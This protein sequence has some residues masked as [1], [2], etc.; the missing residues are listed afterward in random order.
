MGYLLA[1]FSS[2]L[3]SNAIIIIC[4]SLQGTLIPL[5]GGLEN[6]AESLL[7]IIGGAYYA[8]FIFGSIHCAKVVKRAGHIRAF[9]VFASLAS[10]NPL[11]HGMFPNE[12]LWI[13]LRSLSG[14]CYAGL[15]LVIESWL[16]EQVDRDNRGRLFAVYLIVNLLSLT[17]AQLTINLAS[18]T[19]IT[20]FVLTSILASLALLPV[21]LTKTIQPAPVERTKLDLKALWNMSP[22]G[23]MGCFIVGIS[24]GPLWTLGPV[25]AQDAGLG[26]RE[27]SF[28][29]TA[30][31]LGGAALQWPIGRLS[32]LTDRRWIVIVLNLGSSLSGYLLIQ[33]AGMNFFLG[34][35][36]SAVVLGAFSLNLYGVCVALTN[37]NAPKGD[38]VVVSGGLLLV[39]SIGAF[40]GPL[41]VS[42]VMIYLGTDAIFFFTATIHSCFIIF[43]LMRIWIEPAM[44]VSE[45][46]NFAPMSVSQTAPKP[47]EFDPRANIEKEG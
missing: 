23:L 37:D 21:S 47:L 5:R 7:G 15:I 46:S 41:I 17:L 4:F 29:M 39:F 27:V 10:V 16:N 3:I 44:P 35:L 42:G 24:N 22:V 28:F 43:V 12:Y 1:P 26:F 32:D 45:R 9:A 2:L 31:I 20:L 36:G 18:P 30:I 6:F 40:V 14:Y 11:I 25:F 33:M 34:L 13:P 38:F 19:T 8:G